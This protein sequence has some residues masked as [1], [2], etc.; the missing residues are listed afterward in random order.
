[1]DR[2]WIVV[3][4]KTTGGGEVTTGWQG[5]RIAGKPVARVTDKATCR[6]HGGE[7]TIMT[8]NPARLI[9]GQPVA[10]HDSLL[11]CGCRCISG[12]QGQVVDHG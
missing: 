4:D 11:D 6:K 2:L 9:G 3:S 7:R 1:M 5:F 8:G 10:V 12:R